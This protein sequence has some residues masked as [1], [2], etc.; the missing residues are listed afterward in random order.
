M[1]F[2]H[3]RLAENGYTKEIPESYVDKA[4]GNDDEY[5]NDDRSHITKIDQIHMLLKL[6]VKM[7]ILSFIDGRVDLTYAGY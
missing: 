2:V 3:S 6:M 7:M 5:D 1:T 4:D